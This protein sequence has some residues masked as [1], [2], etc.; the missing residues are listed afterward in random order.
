[1][2]KRTNVQRHETDERQMG[3]F[4][5]TNESNELHVILVRFFFKEPQLS[6]WFS[7]SEN[8]MIYGVKLQLKRL[9]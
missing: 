9:G 6:T 2:Q 7:V 4:Y 1:M 5:W 8:G 3:H